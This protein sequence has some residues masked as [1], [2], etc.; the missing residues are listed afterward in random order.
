[1]SCRAALHLIAQAGGGVV[2]G[3]PQDLSYGRRAGNSFLDNGTRALYERAGCV[4]EGPKGEG[5]T[6]MRRT[7]AAAT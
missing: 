2:E 3:Y 7:V 4:Y 1:M 6:V 5:H